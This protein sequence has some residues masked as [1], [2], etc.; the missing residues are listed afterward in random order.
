LRAT[1]RSNI[2]QVVFVLERQLLLPVNA[3]FA[4]SKPAA[5]EQT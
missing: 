5:S 1:G 4:R 2:R 3:E